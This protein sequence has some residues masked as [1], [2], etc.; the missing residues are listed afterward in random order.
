MATTVKL[1]DKSYA[2]AEG[3]VREGRFGS[4][5]QAVEEGLHQLLQELNADEEDAA[6][7]EAIRQGLAD[8]DAGRVVDGEVVLERLLRRYRQSDAA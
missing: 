5:E 2:Y 7:N 6:T 3:L 8:A 1:S 4:I